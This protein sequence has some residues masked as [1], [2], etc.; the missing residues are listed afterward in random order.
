MQNQPHDSASDN[1]RDA[2]MSGEPVPDA[3]LTMPLQEPASGTIRVAF[4]IASGAEVVDFAGPWGVFEYVHIGDA[5]R[6]PFELYTVAVGPQAVR[7]SGGM[8]IVP[9]H[10]LDNAP[11]PDIVVVPALDLEELAPEALDWLRHVHE[12]TV[13]T[14]SVCNGAFV[15]G[16]AGLL[17]GRSA[18]THHQGYTSLQAMFPA[19]TVLRGRRFVEDGR[20]ATSGGL[21]SGIDLALRIVERFYGRDTARRTASNLEY[22][23]TGWMHPDSNSQF[24]RHPV[25]TAQRPVCPICEMEVSKDTVHTR[26]Y[27]GITRY[28]CGT[29]CAEHFDTAPERYTAAA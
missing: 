8:T 26:E 24:A 18:T 3:R 15:L 9:N 12:R 25:G 6:N 28:F 2:F 16:R 20:I 19:V 23:G 7:V 10:G 17:D 27:E 4:L 1:Q 21:T 11:G 29:S 22:Q 13:V 14:M 5:R